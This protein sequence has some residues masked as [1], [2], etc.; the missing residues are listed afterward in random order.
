[1]VKNR[2]TRLPIELIHANPVAALRQPRQ[3]GLQALIIQTVGTI[4]NQHPDSDCFAKV[5]DSLCL[6]GS[7]R[8]LAK[9]KLIELQRYYFR[10]VGFVRFR[11]TFGLPPRY[12][13]S[14]V[15]RVI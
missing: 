5:F 8:S 15:V 7:G 14:A 11:F 2:K 4:V 12:I 10:L 9:M 3:Y 13:W 6:T 1:M